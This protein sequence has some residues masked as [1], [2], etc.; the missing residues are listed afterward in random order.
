MKLNRLKGVIPALV[1]PFD[2]ND[3]VDPSALEALTQR[4]VDAGVHGLMV[5]GGTGEFPHL[6]REERRLVAQVVADAAAGRVPVIAG[7][8][9][10]SVREALTLS[11]DAARS[12]VEAVILVPPFYFPLGE[13]ALVSFFEDV[14]EGRPSLCSHTTTLSTRAIRCHHPRSGPFSN[15]RMLSD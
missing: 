6:D 3:R 8:A 13:R 12:G 11:D 14:A 5:T 2:A 9:A 1:T 7:T 4:L 10:C 15:C